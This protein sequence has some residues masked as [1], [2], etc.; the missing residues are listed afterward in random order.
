MSTP[1]DPYSPQPGSGGQ[2]YGQQPGY[3]P[4]PQQQYQGYVAPKK[5]LDLAR[6]VTIGAWVVLGLFG[7]NFLYTLTQDDEFGPD[8]A[9]RLFGS[10]PTLGQG[11]FWTGV[12]LAVGVWLG[13]HQGST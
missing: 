11:I 8:F 6:L 3:P 9:D 4:Y 1:H 2:G 5:S 12:L 10:M 7:L 13:R